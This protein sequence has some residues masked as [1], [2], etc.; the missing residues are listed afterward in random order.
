MPAS[1]CWQW[2]AA[3]RALRPAVAL[4]IAAVTG[5]WS[6]HAAS[7]TAAA[8][9]IA[10][11]VSARRWRTA[12]KR[13]MGWSNWIALDARARAPARA[14]VRDAPTSSCATRAARSATAAVPLDRSAS[15]AA[16]STSPRISTSPSHGSMPCTGRVSSA[17]VSTTAATCPSPVAATTNVDGR[18][19]V[20]QAVAR[21]GGRRSS[22]AGAVPPADRRA[23]PPRSRRRARGRGRTRRRGRA[24]TTSCAA[25]PW[26]SNSRDTAAADRTRA[27][28][29]SPARRPRRRARRPS[30]A[31]SRRAGCARTAR[32]R[33]LRSSVV[34]QVEQAAGDDVALDLGAAAVDASPPASRGTRCASVRCRR[35]RRG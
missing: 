28:R 23:A 22:C 24:P 2:R 27:R 35:R 6:S 34:P 18:A 1:T 31:R 29:P 21:R 25:S 10:T 12:W 7:S 3:V 9:S 5:D 15:P 17:D 20:A 26:S 11:S 33:R 13:A 30:A 32:G 19:A 14:A 4:A 8:V 16:T